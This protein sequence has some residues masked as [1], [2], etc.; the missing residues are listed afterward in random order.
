MLYVFTGSDTAAAK[1]EARKRSEGYELVILGDGGEPFENMMTYIGA[2]GLFAPKIALIADRM[3]EDA[4]GAALIETH[5]EALLQS[6]ALI[7]LI[8]PD[9]GAAEKKLLPKGAKIES[10]GAEEKAE[11]RPNVFAFTD[12]FMAGGQKKDVD[13][14]PPPDRGRH[15]RRGDTRRAVVGGALSLDCRQDQVRRRV[16]PQAVCIR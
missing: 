11:E 9:L 4:D 8:E 10:F 6:D 2:S 7:F 16:R 3:M 14:V 15:Q 1:V 12:S 5:G 13:R